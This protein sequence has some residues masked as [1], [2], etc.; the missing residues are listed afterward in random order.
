M[1]NKRIG[2]IVAVG[3]DGVIGNRATNT[4]P[5]YIPA[6]LKHF[7]S[8]T[9]G[10]TIIMGS[11]T[12]R[13]IGRALPN[14]RNVVLTRSKELQKQCIEEYGVDECYDSLRS[15]LSN[16]LTSSIIIGGEYIYTEAIKQGVVTDLYV[17]VVNHNFATGKDDVYF[18]PGKWFLDEEV[19]IDGA[20][21][22]T[23]VVRSPWMSENNYEFQF[24][25]FIKN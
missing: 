21:R 1:S 9:L 12:F 23:C 8:I 6:D 25:R 5:W 18:K 22:Y 24:T 15:A 2:L 20:N 16:E 7:R 11:N 19:N 17:T 14:R 3:L 10:N 4:M 13:S